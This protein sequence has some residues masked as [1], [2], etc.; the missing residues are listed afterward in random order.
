MKKVNR[1]R[2]PKWTKKLSAAEIK[3]L[4]NDAGGLRLSTLKANL[5]AQK[6]ASDCWTCWMIGQKLGLATT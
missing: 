2:L 1:K 4:A 6:D 3:H 5:A